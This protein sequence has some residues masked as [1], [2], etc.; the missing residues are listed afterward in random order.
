MRTWAQDTPN[1][2]NCSMSY[3]NLELR[4]MNI[5]YIDLSTAC[6]NSIIPADKMRSPRARKTLKNIQVFMAAVQTMVIG[7]RGGYRMQ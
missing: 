6:V 3:S 1:I 7:G 2:S 5:G 4:I